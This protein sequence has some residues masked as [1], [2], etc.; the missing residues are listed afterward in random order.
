MKIKF[1]YGKE[2]VPLDIMLSSINSLSDMLS[3]KYGLH[4][5]SMTIYFN[6]YNEDGEQSFLVGPNGSELN[7][8]IRPRPYK[9]ERRERQKAFEF[10]DGTI[11]Y[12][13]ESNVRCPN[14]PVWPF[15]N[16]NEGE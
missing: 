5:G 8:V 2:R 13:E 4:I 3:A 1:D 9:T 6:L 11:A 16:G 7:L 15:A 12:W 10:S 14:H